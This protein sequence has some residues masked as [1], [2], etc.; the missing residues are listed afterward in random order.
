MF[1]KEE[2]DKIPLF[3]GISPETAAKIADYF[4]LRIFFPG[5]HAFFR[6]EP[7][8]SMFVLKGKVVVTLTNAEGF[9]YTIVSLR[10]GAFFGELGL[11]AG[12]PRSAHVKALTPVLAAEIDQEAYLALIQ[13]FPDFKSRRTAT[14]GKTCCQG[15]G[16]MAGRPGKIS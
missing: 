5:E 10:E 16:A 1:S 14:P 4:S 12:E 15:K 13:A 8:H 6:G 3:Q 11:L 7:A 9:D 2:L